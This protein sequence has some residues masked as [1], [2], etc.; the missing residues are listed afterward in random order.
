M[1]CHKLLRTASDCID[2]ENDISD[3]AFKCYELINNNIFD[4]N[5]LKLKR[6]R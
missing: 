2:I 3:C 4:R 1:Y 6:K 5:I